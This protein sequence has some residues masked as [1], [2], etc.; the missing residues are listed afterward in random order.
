MRADMRKYGWMMSLCALLCIL[1]LSGCGKEDVAFEYFYRGFV[2]QDNEQASV[3]EGIYV[4]DSQALYE[5]FV[6]S[7]GL[8]ALYPLTEIDF[9]QESLIYYGVRSAMPMRG[10]TGEIASLSE[11]TDG[12]HAL[13]LE[14]DEA[15][16]YG[17]E[18]EHELTGYQILAEAPINVITVYMLKVEKGT[19]SEEAV[20]ANAWFGG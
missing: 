12:T 14:P 9:A 19:L 13:I 8:N 17:G 2:I 10:W 11:S 5:T 18:R 4:I 15:L 7:S 20:R 3:P 1:A 6:S 16:V